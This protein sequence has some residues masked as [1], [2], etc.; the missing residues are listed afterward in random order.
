MSFFFF[1]YR[2]VLCIFTVFMPTQLYI[3]IYLFFRYVIQYFVIHVADFFATVI[4]YDSCECF[5]KNQSYKKIL[6][7]SLQ[8]WDIFSSILFFKRQKFKK[9]LST[10]YPRFSRSKAI[11]ENGSCKGFE[12]KSIDSVS[13]YFPYIPNWS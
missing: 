2:T 4:E 6:I 10:N 5:V 9:S 1:P 7:N 12:H 11:L 8:P 13:F 3:Y